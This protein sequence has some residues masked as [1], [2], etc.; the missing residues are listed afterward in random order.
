MIMSDL[1]AE[2]I[3]I[4]EAGRR[5]NPPSEPV[6]K[7][8]ASISPST[9]GQEEPVH[10]FAHGQ[11]QGNLAELVKTA[12]VVLENFRPGTMAADGFSYEDLCKIKPDIIAHSVSGFGQYG[13]YRERPASTRWAR[14]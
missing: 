1:G 11:G 6:V 10:G 5:G 4:G 13:P 3:K 7:A 2:V 8:S 14:R 12:D 9:T